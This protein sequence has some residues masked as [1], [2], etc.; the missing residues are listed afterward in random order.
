M[1][2]VH[3]L[4]RAQGFRSAEPGQAVPKK[5]TVAAYGQP[6]DK[7]F[8]AAAAG[9]V[10]LVAPRRPRVTHSAVPGVGG[11]LTPASACRVPA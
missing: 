11:G 5:V 8:S 6:S 4:A 10:H 9:P 1:G 7:L 2:G 3:Y